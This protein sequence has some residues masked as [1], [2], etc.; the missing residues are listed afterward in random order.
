MAKKFDMKAFSNKDFS[1]LVDCMQSIAD[2]RS[3]P[4]GNLLNKLKTEINRIFTEKKCMSVVYSNNT[5]KLFFGM[6]VYPTVTT[7]DIGNV[8]ANANDKFS[9]TSNSRLSN[10]CIEIDSRLCDKMLALSGE[11]LAAILLHEIGHMVIDIDSSFIN[12][13]NIIDL[14]CSKNM[15]TF[16]RGLAAKAAPLFLMAYYDYLRKTRSF[17]SKSREEEIKADLF[18]AYARF[19]TYLMGAYRTITHNSNYLNK[20]VKNKLLVFDWAMKSYRDMGVL[21]LDV[22]RKLNKAK[23]FT[24]SII[25]KSNIDKCMN[26]MNYT[27]DM[28]NS[29]FEA[30]V[31]E[32]FGFIDRMRKSG[33]KGIRN[34][35]YELRIQS[36]S[37]TDE[38]EC[39]YVLRK[40]NSRIGIL[41]DY[42]SSHSEDLPERELTM[43]QDTFDEYLKLRE[44]VSSKQMIRKTKMYGLY[45]DYN[46]LPDEYLNSPLY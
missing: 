23:T 6:S 32:G 44:E 27:E 24:A 25:E 41:D 43:W 20:D 37:A 8:V 22:L 38:E 5:D 34:E 42:L 17:F 11:H 16:D 12:F 29:L 28:E 2:S 18:V 36:K 13:S 45:T 4:S 19:D 7:T 31:Q 15:I 3:I 40:I 10:Y 14:Y 1:G 21:R 26:A 9:V 30:A 33:L 39:L 35:L 46:K